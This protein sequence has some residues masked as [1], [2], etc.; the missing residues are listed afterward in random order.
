MFNILIPLAGK[1][2]RFREKNFTNPKPLISINGLSLIKLVI[3]SI[4]IEGN[5]IFIIQKIDN[6]NKRLEQEIL[7]I[8]PNS[9]IIEIDYYTNGSAESCLIAK[10]YINNENELFITNCDQIFDINFDIFLEYINKSNY[11]GLVITEKKRDPSYSY[12]SCDENKKALELREKKIISEQ[13]LI[14][15]H[16]WKKGSD[17]VISAE[18]IIANNEKD[19]NEYYISI[20]YNYLIKCG[21]NISYYEMLNTDSY[22]VIGT[23]YE[24]FNYLFINNINIERNL[25]EIFG[26]FF[27][28]TINDRKNQKSQFGGIM[29]NYRYIK[30]R[31]PETNLNTYSLCES[32]IYID[33]ITSD[34]IN[35]SFFNLN[36][37]DNNKNNNYWLHMA[38]I[39]NFQLKCDELYE[40]FKK[41]IIISADTC[42]GTNKHN[43]SKVYLEICDY[44]FFSSKDFKNYNLDLC[45]LRGYIIVH[46]KYETC[47]YN[48]T[49]LIKTIKYNTP[50]LENINTLGAGDI[51]ASSFIINMI[52]KNI[53]NI[54]SITDAIIKSHIDTIEYLK[55]K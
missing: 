38:Y 35:E 31:I 14:G 54:Y 36:I 17:F 4:R 55:N 11:D 21:K 13:A 19:N 48:K 25:L 29:N 7:S 42:G 6:D 3:N 46:N 12:I 32:Y 8:K 27:I 47:I 15:F 20:T 34:Y 30:S 5:F 37:Y 45:F 33:K 26:H 18:H 51:F 52:G 40:I 16:Y 10:E 2:I 50:V 28:D 22:H 24:Y 41:N 49:G 1:G 43:F 39:N 53:N 44:I 9:I 23:P